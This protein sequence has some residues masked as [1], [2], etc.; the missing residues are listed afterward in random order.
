MGLPKKVVT[1]MDILYSMP[2]KDKHTTRL[3]NG[4]KATF[5][6][7][8][9]DFPMITIANLYL[10]SCV[11]DRLGYHS[12]V[13]MYTDNAAV[14]DDT[15][16]YFSSGDPNRQLNV[17]IDIYSRAGVNINRTKTH[18]LSD[19]I[20]SID[21]VKRVVDSQGIIPYWIPNLLVSKERSDEGV[22]EVYRYYDET[23]NRDSCIR[24]LTKVCGWTMEESISIMNLHR[25]N[26]GI[27]EDEITDKDLMLYMARLIDLDYSTKI[28]DNGSK[29]WLKGFKDNLN[30]QGLHLF[31]TPF[32]GYYSNYDSLEENN[33]MSVTPESIDQDIYNNIVNMS[34][35]GFK[36][37]EVDIREWLGK[38]WI[39]VKDLDMLQDYMTS[40][41][42]KEDRDSIDNVYQ[43]I[44]SKSPRELDV[45][46]LYG[47]ELDS[48][49]D[50]VLE[51]NKL[52][53]FHLLTNKLK[54]Q[55]LLETYF[56][57]DYVY[58]YIGGKKVRLYSVLYNSQ[59]NLPTNAELVEMGLSTK[60][61]DVLRRTMPS[62]D[63]CYSFWKDLL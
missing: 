2:I 24:V 38:T 35:I 47:K 12:L 45:L 53:S 56:G 42:F 40:F 18:T 30:N 37:S 17:V 5:Q 21:F 62:R 10:Q 25:I 48:L 41:R 4:T 19:G 6:G 54:C 27:R 39:D 11:R 36:V 43:D 58:T 32:M 26:G 57:H 9:G 63:E 28:S 46:H 29:R 34:R 50:Y 13:D 15:C 44:L 23:E 1:E 14:G 49:E 31:D 16:F 22:R 55:L 51:S 3:F 7:Q 59:Y 33:S 60:E 20:G 61:I 52:E 8:Y